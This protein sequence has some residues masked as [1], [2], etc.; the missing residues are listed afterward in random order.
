MQPI[1]PEYTK[2]LADNG[3][4]TEWFQDRTFWLDHNMIKGFV[5]GGAARTA[6]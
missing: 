4:N 6:L 3:C 5:R 2:F 1:F